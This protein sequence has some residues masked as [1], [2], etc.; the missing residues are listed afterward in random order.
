MELRTDNHVFVTSTRLIAPVSIIVPVF[1]GSEML[2]HCLAAI[3]K[4]HIQPAEVIVADDGSTEA[5]EPIAQTYAARYIRVGDSPNGPGLARNEAVIA[6]TQPVV[7]FVD[8]DVLVHPNAVSR[9]LEALEDTS[10]DAVFGSYDEYPADPGFLSQYKNLFHRYVHQNAKAEAETFWSGCG[11]MRRD[12]FLSLGGFDIA[13]YVRPSIEDIDLGVRLRARGGRI[14][15]DK[16]LL[17]THLKRWTLVGL[18]RTEVFD[19]GIPWTR[20]ILRQGS[21]PTD[22]NLGVMERVSAILVWVGLAALVAGKT[23]LIGV[24]SLLTW[25][26]LNRRFYAYLAANRGWLFAARSVPMH[27]LYYLYSM[28]SFAAGV[29]LHLR[30]RLFGTR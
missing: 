13:I 20:L 11:A 7:F 22:L 27:A 28:L 12:V 15:L 2:K 4:S 17:G 3:G 25:L 26:A 23:R 5:I 24:A 30:S 21:I 6:A 29:A 19:R 14:L 16:G 18:L 1:N 9:V 8:T 10:V